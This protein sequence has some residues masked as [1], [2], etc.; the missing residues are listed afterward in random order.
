MTFDLYH[1]Q[2]LSIFII[3]IGLL[4]YFYEKTTKYI[5][6]QVLIFLLLMLWI[7]SW[8]GYYFTAGDTTLFDSNFYIVNSIVLIYLIVKIKKNWKVENFTASVLSL[9][10]FWI[11]A[12]VIL[13]FSINCCEPWL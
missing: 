6:A 2:L 11:L 10:F 3:V 13:L 7:L 8:I 12:M 1:I 4:A 9:Y 5:F